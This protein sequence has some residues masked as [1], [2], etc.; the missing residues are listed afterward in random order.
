MFDFKFS[1]PQYSLCNDIVW[2]FCHSFLQGQQAR[3]DLRITAHEFDLH[4]EFMLSADGTTA[5]IPT[6]SLAQDYWAVTDM[7]T[8]RKEL[9]GEEGPDRYLTICS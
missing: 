1:D 5:F 8:L 2:I 7:L 9:T 3:A 4:T 6:L